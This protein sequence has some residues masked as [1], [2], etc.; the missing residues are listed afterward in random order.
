M[1]QPQIQAQKPADS[2]RVSALGQRPNKSIHQQSQMNL[3]D[4]ICT[5]NSVR[6]C[7]NFPTR[8]QCVF[9]SN[10]GCN[11]HLLRST[12]VIC[13]RGTTAE[14]GKQILFGLVCVLEE[15]PLFD[16]SGVVETP[17]DID[18]LEPVSRQKYSHLMIIGMM[19]K[20]HCNALGVHMSHSTK[21]TDISDMHLHRIIADGHI[22]TLYIH[23]QDWETP[24]DQ[25]PSHKE[26]Q[27]QMEDKKVMDKMLWPS[28]IACTW[29]QR[30]QGNN[31]FR[32]ATSSY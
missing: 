27:N 17:V 29:M 8:I 16:I 4:E 3:H 13:G 18:P 5:V 23:M 22:H 11:A 25:L 21:H 6:A 32:E 15:L 24:L 10:I 2:S 9:R 19:L 7:I 28:S 31:R 14:T 20:Y 30:W 12:S 1:I 26:L